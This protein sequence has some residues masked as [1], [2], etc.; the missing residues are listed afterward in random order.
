MERFRTKLPETV[1]PR[2][3]QIL[4][5]MAASAVL[6]CSGLYSARHLWAWSHAAAAERSRGRGDWHAEYQ[7]RK[8]C[9]AVWSGSAQAHFLAARAARRAG[10]FQSAE[11]LLVRC[12]ELGWV[13]EA[14]G[15]EQLLLRLGRGD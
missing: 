4:A 2:R 7:H 15:D 11:E 3:A 6:G 9:L 12:A 1:R 10:D 5:V 8:K 13:P 14:V